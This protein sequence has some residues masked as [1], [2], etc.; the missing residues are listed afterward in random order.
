MQGWRLGAMICLPILTGCTQ[1]PHITSRAQ[2]ESP[3]N[4]PSIS[5]G[6]LPQTGSES[7]K[8]V[9][10]VT[11]DREGPVLVEPAESR[12]N[13]MVPKGFKRIDTKAAVL[14]DAVIPKKNSEPR[15]LNLPANPIPSADNRPQESQRAQGPQATQGPQRPEPVIQQAKMLKGHFGDSK[16]AGGAVEGEANAARGLGSNSL[17]QSLHKMRPEPILDPHCRTSPT[18]AGCLLNL[19]PNESAIERAIELAKRLDASEADRRML[20]EKVAALEG[21]IA[22]R[23]KLIREDENQL[24][25]ATQEILQVR[26]ELQKLRE[27]IN[28]LRKKVRD[29]EKEELDS[30]KMI[31]D[32]LES[33]L[34][35]NSP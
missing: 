7:G 18:A 27:E 2:F 5:K 19:G 21:T 17:G 35:Q 34:K 13:A 10:S 16:P 14:A 11:D 29:V 28:K 12:P 1:L 23:D 4:T 3:P 30:L 24:L 25:Q 20:L 33:F 9:I 15:P 26:S 6:N 22:S 31:I 32:A 8:S